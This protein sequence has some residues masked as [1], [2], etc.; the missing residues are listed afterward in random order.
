MDLIG[1]AG[2]SRPD[3]YKNHKFKPQDSIDYF[4]LSIEL[5]RQALNM[6]EFYLVAH[7]L[8]G[9][10]GGN[11]AFK[12]PQYVKKLFLLSPVGLRVSPEGERNHK[13]G[14]DN[15][16]F[17]DLPIL[18]PITG[19]AIFDWFHLTPFHYFRVIGPGACKSHLGR[20]TKRDF[21]EKSLEEQEAIKNY[22]F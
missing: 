4:N 17:C 3:N 12:Y 1:M 2:S 11:Y 6:K 22:R 9:H 15:D 16:G 8:G 21:S 5:W 18:D 7:S 14:K 19:K 13:Y 20:C 10:I